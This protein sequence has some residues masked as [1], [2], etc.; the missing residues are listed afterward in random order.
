MLKLILGKGKSGKTTMLL[1]MVQ[2]CPST[3]MASRILIVPD[4]L[5]HQ[6]ERKL[7]KLCG[8]EISFYADVLSFSRLS[9]RVFSLYGGGARNILDEAGRLLSADLALSTIRSRLKVFASA[10]GKAE[11]L[12]TMVNMIDE[13]KSYAVSANDLRRAAANETGMFAEKLSEL[14]LIL[15]A[16]DATLVQGS[17][18][19]RDKMNLLQKKLEQGDYACGRHFFVDGFTDFSG[20]EMGILEQLLKKGE[21]MTITLPCDS[22]EADSSLFAPGRTTANALISLAKAL[23][24]EVDI[25]YA[26]Y[27]RDVSPEISFLADHLFTYPCEKY[28]E[29]FTNIHLIRSKTIYQECLACAKI[30]VDHAMDGMR[31]SD[32]QI[33]CAMEPEYRETMELI[34]LRLNIPLYTGKKTVVTSNGILRFLLLALEC[35][36]EGMETEAVTAYLKTGFSGA[37]PDAVDSIENY[38]L[39]WKIR[40]SKWFS[41][42][43]SHPDGYD[44]RFTDQTKE[45]LLE[46]NQAK[47]RLLH[48]LNRLVNGIKTAG[49]VEQQL[50]C[51]YTFMEDTKLYDTLSSRIRVL[52]E[53]D[54][55]EEAQETA[56]IYEIMLSCL[57]QT[58]A[59]LGKLKLSGRELLKVLELVLCQYEVGTIPATLNHVTF[60]DISGI[61]GQEPKVLYVLG[62]TQSA[63]PGGISGGS[64][65][66]ES[67]R[68]RL[69]RAHDISLAPD[70]E[71]ALQR[72]LLQVYAAFVAPTEELYLSYPEER[73]GEAVIPSYLYSRIMNLGVTEEEFKDDTPYTPEEAVEAWLLSLPDQAE[74]RQLLDEHEIQT[75]IESAENAALP[76]EERLSSGSAKALFGD[77]VKLT[78]SKLDS[79]GK[80]PLD[81][82]L[83]YGIKAKLRKEATFD[84][85]EF[86]TFVHHILEKA[87]SERNDKAELSHDDA[88][89]LVSKYKEGYLEERTAGEIEPRDQYLFQR[90]A[91]EAVWILRDVL[92]EISLSSF[93]PVGYELQFGK[94]GPLPPLEIQG[95]TGT[96]LLEGLVDRA[97]RYST[98][99]GD[100]LRIVDYKTGSKTF[101]FT[102][103]YSGVG[104]QMLLYLFAMKKDGSWGDIPAGVLYCPAKR[105]F[106]SEEDPDKVK[107]RKRSGIVLNEEELL[108]AMEDNQKFEYLPVSN[109]KNRGDH[110]ITRQQMA[111]LE[112]FITNKTA[113]VVD[114]ILNG[115][116]SPKPFY[117]GISNSP[118]TYCNHG[119]ICRKDLQ[120]RRQHYHEPVKAKEFWERIGGGED[121][122]NDADGTTEEGR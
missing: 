2:N 51:L 21:S 13:L 33:A 39:T 108:L 30:L 3:S 58:A 57:E 82:F 11:F 7:C 86:G 120:F 47:D 115:D 110:A 68:T 15:E 112:E 44:G 63:L 43:T 94:K 18:D 1:N 62:C 103:I 25:C 74:L 27:V 109:Q 89:A 9:A 65:L 38:A 116:F 90:N 19:P 24:Q 84:A 67:E 46:L 8:D 54:R 17:F 92:R 61:R 100:F 93:I 5:S 99:E 20:Q 121:G 72:K 4:Q 16:Y 85:A 102:D 111:M 101:D 73:G 122:S 95:K 117:R 32:M 87:L 59:V 50:I 79:Y 66:S 118:C 60:T 107:P 52:S 64:L 23:G 81:F 97:D 69:L 37:E 29:P 36:V 10:S 91:E 41:Q 75:M 113:E 49:N 45:F 106:E 70:E 34:A 14:A 31:W 78:A 6:T 104:M 28:P 119:E 76:R 96:G 48:P 42:W 53:Q 22:L 56:Q 71:T 114:R 98:E 12:S 83:T 88:K 26:G 55:L 105:P 35:A 77:P 80:C 40:G